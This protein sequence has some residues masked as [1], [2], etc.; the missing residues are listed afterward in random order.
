[1]D[2]YQAW[3]LCHEGRYFEARRLCVGAAEFFDNTPLAG[4][5]VL[6]HLLLARIALQT[7]DT[8]AGQ[9]EANLALGKLSL[10][11]APVL[12]YQTHLLLGQIAALRRGIFLARR[13]DQQGFRERRSFL[14]IAQIQMDG[15]HGSRLALTR[16]SPGP[17][18]CEQCRSSFPDPWSPSD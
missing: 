12:M 5:A 14:V 17:P 1:L 9:S 16:M 10:A 2:L 7:A 8:I 15:G 6:C 13:M 11:Q 3:V 4:K 18:T